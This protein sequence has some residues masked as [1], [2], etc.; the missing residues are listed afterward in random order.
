MDLILKKRGCFYLSGGTLKD[1]LKGF[2]FILPNLELSQGRGI[3]PKHL[4][5]NNALGSA[6]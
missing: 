6:G 2:S 5:A 4:Q 3:Y 1:E